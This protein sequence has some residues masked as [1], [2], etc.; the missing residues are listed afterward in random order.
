M[1]GLRGVIEA[2]GIV[3]LCLLIGLGIY[4]YRDYLS[5]TQH[6]DQLQEMENIQASGIIKDAYTDDYN[7]QIYKMRVATVNG[8]HLFGK[9]YILRLV[10]RT[11]AECRAGDYVVTTGHI[12]KRQ[13]LYNPG[14]KQQSMQQYPYRQ[15][16]G[17][18][19]ERCVRQDMTS[20]IMRSYSRYIQ[21]TKD[22]HQRTLQRWRE[23]LPTFDRYLLE[24]L[25]FGDRT[26][27]NQDFIKGLKEGGIIHV[28]AVS[29]MHIGLL[30][31]ILFYISRLIPGRS[32][33]RVI[34]VALLLGGYV[35]MIGSPIS[36]FRAMVMCYVILFGMHGMRPVCIQRSLILAAVVCSLLFPESIFSV[37][38]WLS[39][40]SVIAIITLYPLMSDLCMPGK[41]SKRLNKQWKAWIMNS[42]LLSG[43]VLLLTAPIMLYFFGEL[44]F[45]GLLLNIMVLPFVPILFGS[46]LMMTMLLFSVPLLAVPFAAIVRLLSYYFQW[47]SLM[48]QWLPFKANWLP[49]TP[50][51]MTIYYLVMMLAYLWIKDLT[52]DHRRVKK[53]VDGAI[54]I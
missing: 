36:A 23:V 26:R 20:I 52:E 41:Y 4:S 29:G 2:K 33:I 14:M 27:V 19:V 28:F 17:V 37:S 53:E 30:Y 47:L 43:C 25:F 9:R 15:L 40:V 48:G 38:F 12:K 10:D 49:W 13:I 22:W 51:G 1:N 7:R 32:F 11:G 18:D 46:G 16:G 6:Y 8:Q 45:N 5:F 54:R 50:I 35:V 34:V 44:T 39:F 3:I 21:W 24:A 42:V 31:L